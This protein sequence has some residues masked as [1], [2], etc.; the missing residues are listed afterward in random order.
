MGRVDRERERGGEGREIFTGTLC[1][2]ANTA[3]S[4]KENMYGK[5]S[6]FVLRDKYTKIVQFF[7]SEYMQTRTY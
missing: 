1:I 2:E 7:L 4:P 3:L 5:S 6:I